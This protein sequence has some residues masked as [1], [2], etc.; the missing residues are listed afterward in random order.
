MTENTVF[1]RYPSPEGGLSLLPLFSPGRRRSSVFSF[2]SRSIFP[3]AVQQMLSVQGSY[4]VGEI[5]HA[6]FLTYSL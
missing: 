6:A 5:F 2:S 1:F 3:E 4:A